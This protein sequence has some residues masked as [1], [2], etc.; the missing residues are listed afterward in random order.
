MGNSWDDGDKDNVENEENA[1]IELFIDIGD[2][3][4]YIGTNEEDVD[5]ES[6][7][8]I[9]D[10]DSEDKDNSGDEIWYGIESYIGD[11]D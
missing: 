5:I 3:D 1:G 8:D 6:C 9:G 2:G 10:G 4:S 11:G 7:I